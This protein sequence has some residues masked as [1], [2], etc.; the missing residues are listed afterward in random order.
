MAI[1]RSLATLFGRYWLAHNTTGRIWLTMGMIALIVDA[2]LCYQYGITQTVWHGIGFAVVALFFSQLPDGAYSEYAKGNH[3]AGLVLG[4]LCLPLGAVAY[5]SHI[6]YGAGVRLGDIKK[7]MIQ[8]ARYEGAQDTAKENAT[9]LAMW[10][11]QLA[12]LRDANAWTATVT[13][14]ALRAK[15]PG[16]DLAIQLEAKRGGCGR[17]CEAKTR[18]R[19]AIN[20][21]LA[22]AE[23][24]S[25]LSKRIDAT[26]RLVDGARTKAA[27]TEAGMSSVAMQTDANTQLFGVVRAAW[28]G[29]PL[30][31]ALKTTE[32]SA[33][34]AN[35]IITAAGS[36]AF[37][38]MAPIGFFMAGRN[39]MGDELHVDTRQPETITRAMAQNH[40][41]PQMQTQ[42]PAYQPQPIVL[43][44]TRTID[45]GI[46]DRIAAIVRAASV[47]AATA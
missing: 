46:A 25:D 21:Q 14:D 36:L 34:L 8:D 20:A 47:R 5:Q 43:H 27:T 18:E 2:A 17:L 45:S 4:A 31:T 30:E 3:V 13:A 10:R 37:M 7:A 9:N 41:G 22:I 44:E 23:Q 15:L 16:L 29:E 33:K 6:G 39:R 24:T 11:K 19:D 40:Q 1:I 32:Q 38:L 28:T 42:A 26:Q 12:D 35:L